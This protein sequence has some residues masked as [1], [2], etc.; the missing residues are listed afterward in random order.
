ML[1]S[2][3]ILH[4][5]YLALALVTQIGLLLCSVIF[6]ATTFASDDFYTWLGTTPTTGRYYRGA[7]SVVAF[8]LSLIALTVDLRG[9]AALHN[10][11]MK[12]WAIANTAFRRCQPTAGNEWPEARRHEL[13]EAYWNADRESVSIPPSQ[14]LSLKAKHLRK[15]EV[16]RRKSEFPGCPT[17]FLYATVFVQDTCRAAASTLAKGQGK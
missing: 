11:A 8:A 3:S 14:F 17:I 16:S 12:K 10:S 5:R 2:H 4:E 7:A 1:D 9:K 15:M 6:C 13:S